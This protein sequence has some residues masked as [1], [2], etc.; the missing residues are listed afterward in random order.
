MQIC[1]S[2]REPCTYLL[3]VDYFSRYPELV[4]LTSTTAPSV[5]NALKAIFAR[6]GIPTRLRTDNGPQF[7]CAE[8][9]SFASSYAFKH[10]TSSPRYPQSNGEVERCVQT[11][12]NLLKKSDDIYLSML[13][14]RSTPLCWCDQSPAELCMGRKLRTNLP[15]LTKT[16]VPE[17]SNLDK[18]YQDEGRYKKRMKRDFDRRHRV[19]P[20]ND[21]KTHQ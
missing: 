10:T 7:D 15:Q 21:Q 1:S 13:V 5:V 14:Y 8:M 3:V 16:L 9:N 2:L 20:L 19:S 4:K 11:I 17:W 18:F 6:H 12:K